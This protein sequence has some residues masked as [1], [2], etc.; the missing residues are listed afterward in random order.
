V[1][2]DDSWFDQFDTMDHRHTGRV[3][4]PERL[5]NLSD[6]QSRRPPRPRLGVRTG[7]L[8]AAVGG[9]IVVV[10]LITS[11]FGGGDPAATDRAYLNRITVP[12]HDSQTVGAALAALLGDPRLT[13]AK[14]NSAL[15]QLLQRQE[16]DTAEASAIWAAPRLRTEHAQAL[17]ALQL[18][19]SGLSGLLAGFLSAET[20][21]GKK[22]WAAELSAEADRLV[23]SDV[24]WH[25][26]FETQAHAQLTHDGAN[27][28]QAPQ[29]TFLANHD[30]AAAQSMADVLA[31]L[32]PRA[33]QAAVT[34]K[35]GDTGLLV[36]AWQQ[37]LNKWLA[38]QPG[39]QPLS[40]TGIFDQATAT[41]TVQFQTAMHVTP[42]G[43]AGPATR[44]ALTKA[45]GQG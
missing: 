27:G 10:V 30:L 39:Q 5:R 28:A 40:V 14:L 35:L 32:R 38:R 26:L 29:S 17:D 43:I 41:A 23:A 6:R 9:F 45:L 33:A 37:Q 3:W 18:R 2:E 42:D 1:S 4:L 19:V 34:A 13:V 31:R 12:A 36:S 15:R 22:D 16:R 20:P 44:A 8:A 21:S 11:A 24:I 7:R 25:D